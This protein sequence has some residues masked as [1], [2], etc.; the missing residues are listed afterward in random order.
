[1][2]DNTENSI[3]GELSVRKSTQR[4]TSRCKEAF[5]EAQ[6]ARLV[7]L[8]IWAAVQKQTSQC[9]AKDALDSN[10]AVL[11]P[12]RAS[13]ERLSAER[14]DLHHYLWQVSNALLHSGH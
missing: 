2:N 9:R 3:R 1:M 13:S 5:V 8:N 14:N 4:L 11:L 12:T 7:R 6:E 10:D